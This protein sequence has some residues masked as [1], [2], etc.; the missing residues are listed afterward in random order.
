MKIIFFGTPEF[1]AEHLKALVEAGIEILAV[2]TKPDKPQGRSLKVQPAAVKAMAEKIA[3]HIPVFQ[4]EKCSSP[5]FIEVLKQFPA[6]LYVVV[7]YGEIIKQPVI[8]LPPL[9]CINVH[10]SLLP[11]YRGAAPMQ[12]VLMNGETETGI[13]IIQLVLKMDAGDVLYKRALPIPEAMT[14]PELEAALCTLGCECMLKV[15]DDFKRGAIQKEPQEHEKATFA[16]KIETA[17][18]QIDWKRP[19]QEIHNLVRAVIPSPGAFCFVKVRGEQKRLK[20][21]KSKRIESTSKTPGELISISKNEVAVACGR[22]A[23]QLLEV[24]LEGSK[25]MP[26][27]QFLSGVPHFEIVL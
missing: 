6:D 2:V 25:A 4:P 9:G 20:I 14:F 26:A 23:L 27:G 7:A 16:K 11:Y 24:Q 17:E 1:A 15:I 5:E 18:C 10:A 21:L 13:T 22:D 19:A 8:D 12:R 3:P